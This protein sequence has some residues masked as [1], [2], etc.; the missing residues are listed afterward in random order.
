MN[1]GDNSFL[2]DRAFALAVRR[3]NDRPAVIEKPLPAFNYY[4]LSRTSESNIV[5]RSVQQ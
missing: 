1:P 3:T 5:S 2:T 4:E